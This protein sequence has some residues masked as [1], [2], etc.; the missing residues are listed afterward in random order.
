[1]T[2]LITGVAGFI[3]NNFCQKLAKNKKLKIVG[4][5]SFNNYY[6]VKIKK[7]R[8]K[9]IINNK[10]IK[11]YQ[12]NIKDKK[13]LSNLFKKYKFKEVY[14]FAAQAGVR[15]S[16]I[17]PV[18]YI[19]S[20]ITGFI[21]L[22]KISKDFNVKKFFYASSSSVYGDSINFPLKE[23]EQL[24]PKN[25]YG[26]TKKL[27]EDIARNYFENYKF[28]SIGLRFFTVFGEW[29]RP[30]MFMFKYLTAAYH[31]KKFYLNNYGNHVRDFTYINDVT[32]ILCK[33]RNKKIKKNEIYNISSNNP[34]GLK[35]ILNFFQKITPKTQ[36]IKRRF[37]KSDVFKTHG[38]NKIILKKTNYKKFENINKAL[39]NTHDWYLENKKI[40]K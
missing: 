34:I 19:D 30:D 35:E 33:L 36:V 1:M 25:F 10:N 23:T 31:K 6:P 39:K 26:M 17:N 18:A 11:F 9:K 2:I 21:N 7:Q 24:N 29:G 4:I 38:S 5:D 22:I 32:N 40:Y 12:K 13:K 14:N 20:N 8:I 3:G 15:Y 37:Q 27:N 16:E 28:K